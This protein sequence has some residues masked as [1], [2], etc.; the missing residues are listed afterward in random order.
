VYLIARRNVI[1]VPLTG[2]AHNTT[3]GGGLPFYL[4]FYIF[5]Y[6]YFSY[7]RALCTARARSKYDTGGVR[8]IFSSFRYRGRGIRE[9]RRRFVNGH[10]G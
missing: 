2:R 3:T 7:T 9:T 8:V 5:F 1:K 10:P 6:I 4:F